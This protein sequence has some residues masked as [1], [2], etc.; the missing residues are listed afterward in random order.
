[1][2]GIKNKSCPKQHLAVLARAD[3]P[4]LFRVEADRLYTFHAAHR[5]PS[6]HF[7]RQDYGLLESVGL[8]L[9]VEDVD[10]GIVA[11]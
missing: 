2:I 4:G 9:E 7:E 1:V 10:G 8:A 3:Q 6:E 5:M 11:C